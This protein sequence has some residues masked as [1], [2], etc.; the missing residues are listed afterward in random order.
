MRIE[1]LENRRLLSGEKILFVRGA[2]RSGGFLEATNDSQRTEQ[3]ADINNASTSNGNHGWKKLSTLLT[4]EGYVVSQITES[5]EANAPTTGQTQGRAIDFAS[6]NLDQYGVIV[7]ASNNATY[8]DA[9]VDALEQ[10]VLDGGGVLFISDANFGSDWRDAPMSDQKFLSK[11]GV[12]VNQ[13]NDTYTLK[14]SDGH[15]AVPTSPLLRDVDEIDGEGVSPFTLGTA[16]SGVQTRRIVVARG[17]VFNNNGNNASN[18]YRG[19][20]RAAGANDAA[21]F[22]ALADSGRVVGHFDRNTFFNTNGAGTN[23]TRFDNTQFARNVFDFLADNDS[24]AVESAMVS[25]GVPSQVLIEFDDVVEG[26]TKSN[27]RVRDRE[28]GRL[29]NR[30]NWSIIVAETEGNSLATFRI[31]GKQGDGRYQIEIL[32]KKLT[33]DANNLR[34]SQVTYKFTIHEEVSGS[35]FGVVPVGGSIDFDF[36]EDDAVSG[37]TGVSPVNVLE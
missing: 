20:S 17:T 26:L 3:L 35:S 31:K 14:R 9:S 16:P 29:I 12:T 36:D 10:F 22:A 7:L 34:G 32:G 28:T 37:G 23:I 30:D 24:P 33:D 11:F 18:Q 4:N 19:T 27:A 6:M 2:D 15:F 13:D 21:V 5:L 25:P 8:S 1:A